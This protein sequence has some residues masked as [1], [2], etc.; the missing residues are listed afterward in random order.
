[1]NKS[2]TKININ[3][4]K[5]KEEKADMSS[6][7]NV[8]KS[9]NKSEIKGQSQ[10]LNYEAI[11]KNGESRS[12]M[13]NVVKSMMDDM[14]EFSATTRDQLQSINEKMSMEYH[15]FLKFTHEHKKKV[16]SLVTDQGERLRKIEILKSLKKKL[17]GAN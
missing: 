12:F 2:F 16:E 8:T 14:K 7:P 4:Q 17:S 6:S 15:F 3:A 1:M 9:M 10:N 11:V 5:K 13:N